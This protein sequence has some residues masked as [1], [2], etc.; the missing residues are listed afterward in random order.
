MLRVKLHAAS[1]V[2]CLFKDHLRYMREKEGT[3]GCSGLSDLAETFVKL[4]SLL[5]VPEAKQSH[6]SQSLS[7]ERFSISL[8]TVAD[9][10]FGSCF[11]R[12]GG[13]HGGQDL[14]DRVSAPDYHQPAWQPSCASS[15]NH[16]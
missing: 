14:V 16:R 13:Q 12:A 3:S 5:A 9:H 6:C 10:F 15:R 2:Y 4:C 1:G 8:A 11:A 7:A